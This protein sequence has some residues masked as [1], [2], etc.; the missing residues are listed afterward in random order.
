MG[1]LVGKRE[2]RLPK[3][4]IIG[5]KKCG[6]YALREMLNLH[7]M[8]EI[9]DRELRFFIY[10]EFYAKGLQYYREQMPFSYADQITIEKTPRYFLVSKTPQRI[11]AMDPDIKLILLVRDPVTRAISE[12]VHRRNKWDR[13]FEE[14]AFFP[15]GSINESYEPIRVSQYHRF[16]PPWLEEFPREQLIVVN[17]DE[18]I[19]DPVSQL[20]NIET[21]LGLEHKIT[22]DD[23]YFSTDK[24]FYCLR[25]ETG[26]ECLNKKKG[27]KHPDIDPANISKLRRFFADHNKEFYELI[28]E[29]FG[30]P[31]E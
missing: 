30:W 12:Y 22:K 27:R 10:N 17:G 21:F 18:L 9:A 16:L 8:I 28:S 11:K 5:V 14:L 29:N 3:A 15:N 31:E 20:S 6:T 7:P 1:S 19:K 2:Q 24:G 25:K 23:F 13:T 26:D 4:I